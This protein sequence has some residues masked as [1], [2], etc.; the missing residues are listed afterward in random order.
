[1]A[2]LKRRGNW[3]VTLVSNIYIGNEGL[4]FPIDGGPWMYCVDPDGILFDG[5]FNTITAANLS[6]QGNDGV[7]IRWVGTSGVHSFMPWRITWP[8]FEYGPDPNTHYIQILK[9]GQPSP[10]GIYFHYG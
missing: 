8:N 6:T 2:V 1:S 3:Q 7:N 5:Y 4:Y 10:G 9:S